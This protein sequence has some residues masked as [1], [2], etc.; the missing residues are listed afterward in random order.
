[1]RCRRREDSPL[2]K[3]Y[4]LAW[5]PMFAAVR[6][7]DGP[8]SDALPRP[9]PRFGPPAR[10]LSIS[11]PIFPLFCRSSSLACA[12]PAGLYSAFPRGLY[13]DFETY[14]AIPDCVHF[15]FHNIRILVLF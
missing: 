12:I 14:F 15:A 9:W 4:V 13:L 10:T 2:E 5:L 6:F 11:K 3:T 1:M 8:A 7:L